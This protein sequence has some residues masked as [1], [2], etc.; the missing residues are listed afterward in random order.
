MSVNDAAHAVGRSGLPELT[1]LPGGQTQVAGGFD[2]F[3]LTKA[4]YAAAGIEIPWIARTQYNAGPQVPA[5]QPVI[6]KD[7]VFFG[8][9]PNRGTH[10]GIAISATEMIN[11]PHQGAVVQIERIWR[12]HFLGATPPAGSCGA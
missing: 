8:S 11:A 1:E 2:C 9:G 6:P 10:V 4:A 7:L 3:G 12:T 5:G